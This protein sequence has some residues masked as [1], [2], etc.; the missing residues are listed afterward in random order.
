MPELRMIFHGPA[1][2]AWNMAV[3]EALLHAAA[4][5]GRATLRFYEWEEPTL[6]LGH[7][8][9]VAEREQH[10]P[11]LACPLVR[12]ASGGGAILHDRE[13]T[14]SI[15]LPRGT[16]MPAVKLYEIVHQT[17]IGTL[18]SLGIVSALY[19]NDSPCYG[20]ANR[21][22]PEPFMCFERRSCFDI[23]SGGGKVVGSAQR[24][25]Q[26]A[27]LQHG[28][29][30]LAKSTS[31]PELSGIYELTGRKLEAQE[32]AATW[33]PALAEA[34]NLTT[35]EGGMS[36]EELRLADLLAGGRFGAAAY[37]RRR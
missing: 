18:A 21:H 5:T 32:L 34:L 2:G 11:S 3:D 17:L 26:G 1:S 20:R 9:S 28:S 33:L 29:I 6:S 22:T 35:R 37:A 31:A 23:V 19:Q 13:L 15:V 14:Y 24:R 12:R 4:E 36:D 10:R 8:Q 7:F 25:R 27:V 16:A 30:L